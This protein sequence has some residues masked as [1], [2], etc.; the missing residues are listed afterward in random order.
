MRATAAAPAIRK[1]GGR[2]MSHSIR[3]HATLARP[4]RTGTTRSPQAA[5]RGA[6]RNGWT[7]VVLPVDASARLPSRGMVS[8]EGTLN[9]AP[10][11]AAL[12]PDGH[13]GH[14]L[15]VNRRLQVAAGAAAGD[16]VVLDLAPVARDR[17]PEPKVPV[18]LRQALAFAAP[19]ARKAWAGITT[20]ARRDF[21][22][23]I[24]SAKRPATRARR[25]GAACD[26]LAKGKRRPCCF[27]RS[28]VYSGSLPCPVADDRP[29]RG[30]GRAGGAPA[31]R[32]REA[33]GRGLVRARPATARSTRRRRA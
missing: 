19:A 21:I 26:M 31:G 10:F 29:E 6:P 30:R 7:F 5:A 25:I 14:W 18:D 32:A 4:R 12:L 22:H 24:T 16:A 9:G 1:P 28:G 11:R 3:F 15:K 17:E 20:A 8:V 23:W 2:A 27:D 13:G 33:R